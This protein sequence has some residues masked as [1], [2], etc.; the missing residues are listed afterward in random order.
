[1]IDAH[2]YPFEGFSNLHFTQVPDE[3]IDRLAP[4]LTESE[5]RVALYV[6][7]RTFGFKKD[8]DQISLT[9]LTDGIRR[10]DGSVLDRGTGMKRTAVVRALKG[11]E[12]RGIIAALRITKQ[13]GSHG[14]TTY[15][16][17]FKEE[18]GVV[19]QR[20]QGSLPKR[21]GVVSQRDQGVV[22]LEDPQE[23]VEQETVEQETVTPRPPE[24]EI[25]AM[26]S[27]EAPGEEGALEDGGAEKNATPQPPAATS[28]QIDDVEGRLHSKSSERPRKPDKTNGWKDRPD[29]LARMSDSLWNRW[30]Q[31]PNKILRRDLKL[32]PKFV[33]ADQADA[34]RDKTEIYLQSLRG[35]DPVYMKQFRRWLEEWQ[36]W[37]PVTQ[38]KPIVTIHDR[39]LT[40]EEKIERGVLAPPTPITPRINARVVEPELEYLDAF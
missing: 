23:T 21:P 36:E 7:R 25:S 13:D 6:I 39:L 35:K 5:L 20:D 19:S 31:G 38:F 8:A 34:F 14:T 29:T 27:V 17:R 2:A 28:W 10:K 37:E 33:A 1:M 32:I 26:A 11:L 40:V 24:G 3:F 30:S 15:R 4:D 22:S 18:A 12:E 9:Q 16:L